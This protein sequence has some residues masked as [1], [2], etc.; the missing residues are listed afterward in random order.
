MTKSK[1]KYKF[2]PTNIKNLTKLADYLESLSPYYRHFGM[3]SFVRDA[4]DLEALVKYAKENGGV[5]HCGSAACAVGH[6]PSAGILF[7]PSQLVDRWYSGEFLPN[8]DSY[9]K[10]FISE[11]CHETTSVEHGKNMFEWLFGGEWEGIDN[12]HYGAAA[13]IWY[14][15]DGNKIPED[16]EESLYAAPKHKLAYKP[17]RKTYRQHY[18][19]N[20]RFN[21]EKIA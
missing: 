7:K 5:Q 1:I 12:H 4:D 10:N 14:I 2:S 17:Y 6:G 16:F 9:T 21:L 13:R 15:L 19:K 8:W 11:Y 20:N 3:D 18:I